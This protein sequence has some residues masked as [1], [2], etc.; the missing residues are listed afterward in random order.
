MI[1]AHDSVLYYRQSNSLLVGNTQRIGRQNES[2][3]FI[4]EIVSEGTEVNNQCECS[5][6]S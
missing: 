5:V 3:L 4:S 1:L 2:N 6:T